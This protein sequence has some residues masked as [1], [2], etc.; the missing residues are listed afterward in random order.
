[1]LISGEIDIDNAA[2]VEEQI[3]A[4]IDNQATTV[5]L[6][7][8]NVEYMDSA[9]LHILFRLAA[10]LDIL[11]IGLDVVTAVGSPTRRVLE[12]AGFHSLQ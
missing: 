9:G 8:N 6:D 11:Q 10:R 4:A 3:L 2:G 1:V 7:L 5:L 12:L